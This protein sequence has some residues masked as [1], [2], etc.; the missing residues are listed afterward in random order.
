[1]TLAIW[2]AVWTPLTIGFDHAAVLGEGMPFAGIDLF[3][4]TCFWIDI[5]VGFLSSYVD[6]V[7]GDEVYAPK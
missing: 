3:V 5:F 4:D 1:M 6:S 7:S 2:N